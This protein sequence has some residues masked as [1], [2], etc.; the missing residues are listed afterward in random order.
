MQQSQVNLEYELHN[1]PKANPPP[2]LLIYG[3]PN[4]KITAHII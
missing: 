2:L 1:S 4:F 3:N